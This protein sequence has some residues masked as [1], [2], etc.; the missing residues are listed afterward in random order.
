VVV[1]KGN[2]SLGKISWQMSTELTSYQCRSE[3]RLVAQEVHV[4]PSID[5]EWVLVGEWETPYQSSRF[6]VRLLQRRIGSTH[7]AYLEQLELCASIRASSLPWTIDHLM[8]SICKC[9]PK[10]VLQHPRSCKRSL[11]FLVACFRVQSW[12]TSFHPVR[13]SRGWSPSSKPSHL[14]LLHSSA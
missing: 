7:K 10:F 8:V 1:R 5:D 4:W 12:L 6:R 13:T 14:P 11:V 3:I 9:R 2:V